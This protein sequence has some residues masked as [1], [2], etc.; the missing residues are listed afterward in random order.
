MGDSIFREGGPHRITRTGTDQ[1][2]MSFALPTDSDG[3]TARECPQGGCEPGYFKVKPGT[4][5]TGGQEHAYCPYCHYEAPPN[6]FLTREQVRYAKELA[7]NE[8]RTGID[9]MFRKALGL[10]PS[11]KKQLGGGLISVELS[12]KPAPT[13]TARTPVEDEVRRDVVC[14]HCTLDQT[15]FGLATWCADCGADIFITHVEGELAV[16]RLM[17][18]DIER[19]RDTLGGRVGAKDQENCLEDIVSTF[20]AAA[21]AMVRRALAGRGRA[22][23]SIDAEFRKI[24]NAFQNIERGKEHLSRLFGSALPPTPVWDRLGVAFEKRHP[25]THNLGVVDRRYLEKAQ[26]AETAGREVRIT[27]GEISSLLNDVAEA[28]RT[29]YND[30]ALALSHVSNAA[31]SPP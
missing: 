22:T 18:G 2:S 7:V 19:R 14:P 24:G 5:I 31:A 1:Y 4:G 25:I 30:P 10:G 20:E 17:A 29:I 13:R 23:E 11:G 15:V 26:S 6:S 28:V 9:R 3:R 16:I 12:Y 21:K 8:A 27:T